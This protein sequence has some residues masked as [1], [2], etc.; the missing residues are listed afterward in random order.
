MTK[1]VL[2]L[3]LE[4][5]EQWHFGCGAGSAS[6]DDAVAAI[7]EA[8]EQPEQ[9]PIGMLDIE[10]LDKWRNA[11]L[12]GRQKRNPLSDIWFKQSTDWMEF[13]QAIE[14]ELKEKNT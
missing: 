12:K 3:A 7:K 2:K 10:R 11:S 9:E 14:A 5:L 13:A 8:L 1:E 4:A 6:H